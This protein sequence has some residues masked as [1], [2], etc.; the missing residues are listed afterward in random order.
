MVAGVWG[1]DHR[2][3]ARGTGWTTG[4][5]VDSRPTEVPMYRS[6]GLETGQAEGCVPLALR[7]EGQEK[8]GLA[9]SAPRPDG[10]GPKLPV[11]RNWGRAQRP[12]GELKIRTRVLSCSPGGQARKG[13]GNPGRAHSHSRPALKWGVGVVLGGWAG[14]P[15][16]GRLTA[17]SLSSPFSARQLPI[18]PMRRP[19][20][21]TS[22][23]QEG[24][25]PQ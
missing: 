11:V 12:T 4:V 19:S 3:R 21:G 2:A 14:L 17:N 22:Q 25:G 15:L 24:P 5:P 10:V 13:G 18:W 23:G 1:G 7:R 16:S 6:P 9:Q 20:A 8:T